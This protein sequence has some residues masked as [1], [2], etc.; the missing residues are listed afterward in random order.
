M[1]RETHA[2]PAPERPHRF[3]AK[4]SN[5][6]ETEV[7]RAADYDALRSRYDALVEALERTTTHLENYIAFVVNA[8]ITEGQWDWIDQAAAIPA[9]EAARDLLAAA[10]PQGGEHG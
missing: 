3:W 1:S 10:R 2:P 9:A 7:V 6:P 8:R 4:T 5:I